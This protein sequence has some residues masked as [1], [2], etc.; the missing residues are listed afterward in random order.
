MHARWTV[1]CFAQGCAQGGLRA[2]A[3]GPTRARARVARVGFES[4]DT[5]EAVELPAGV[6]ALHTAL[7]K[8]DR[9]NLTHFV[10][11]RESSGSWNRLVSW[12]RALV[13]TVLVQIS[14]TQLS[15]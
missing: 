9:D 14:K 7:A 6:A 1:G 5:H 8:V 11:G 13:A 3:G 12:R 2:Q 15:T 10:L 4:A